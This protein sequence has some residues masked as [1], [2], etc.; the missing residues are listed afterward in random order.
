MSSLAAAAPHNASRS[1]SL[2]EYPL[3]QAGTYAVIEDAEGRVLTVQAEN[4]RFYLPG[5]RIEPGESPRQALV[6]EIAEE[7]GWSAAIA[8]PLRSASQSIMGGRVRLQASHWRA[9]LVA[10]LDS[11]PEH[12][13]VWASREQALACLHRECDRAALRR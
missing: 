3:L 1:E 5:G 10:Q 8:A 2:P 4:G 7:C 6:R 9:R 11:A 13:V 12:K